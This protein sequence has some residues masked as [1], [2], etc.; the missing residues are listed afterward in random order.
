[1]SLQGA[2]RFIVAL[3][4]RPPKSLTERLQD[5]SRALREAAALAPQNDIVR[6]AF[7]KIQT[8]QAT[9]VLHKLCARFAREK[10]AQAGKD[11]LTY[12]KNS[13]G[14]PGDVAK[15]CLE[16]L[17]NAQDVQDKDVQ[18]GI[19]A[20]LLSESAA[21]KLAVAKQLGNFTTKTF[22]DFYEVGDQSANGMTIVV[23]DISSW[24]DQAE[25]H[26]CERDIFQLF[27]AKL[28]EAGHDLDG[29]ALH[30]I[31]RLLAADAGNLHSLLDEETF[32]TVLTC[33][34]YR[35]SIEVRSQATLATA[36]YLEAAEE[37]AQL[38]ISKF[39]EARI[40]RHL[41]EDLVLAFSAAAAIF[42]LAPSIASSLFLTEGFVP[43]LK[44]LLEQNKSEHVKQAGLEMLSAAC[45]DKA[46]REAISKY[47]AE[48]LLH[49]VETD[50]GQKLGLAAVILA[51]VRISNIRPT[52]SK[53]GKLKN[54]NQGAEDLLPL[55]KKM[56]VGDDEASKQSAIEGLA[57]ISVQPRA[58]EKLTKDKAF[59]ETLNSTLRL[60]HGNPNMIFGGLTIID[61]LTRYRA[62]LTEEQ[63]RVNE[64]KA[65]ANG[66]QAA[67]TMDPLDEDAIVTKRCTA[68][69]AAG[70][71]ST[72]ATISKIASSTS[73][74]TIFDILLSLSKTASLRGTIAKQGGVRLLLQSSA[75]IDR[76]SATHTRA[77]RSAAQALARI[78]I[79]IDPALVFTSGS[80]PLTSAIR[81][82]LFLLTDDPNHDQNGPRDLLPTFEALLALTNLASAPSPEAAETII[83]LAFPAIE[84]LL[85]NNNNLIQR[86]AT[87]LVCNLTACAS[88]IE[89]FADDSNPSSGR[90]LHI[91]LALADVDDMQTRRASAGA[92]ATITGF[93]GAVKQILARD[94]GVRILLNLCLDDDEGVVHRGVA[95]IKNLVWTDVKT[96]SFARQK[97]RDQGGVQTLTT[98][99]QLSKNKDILE[100]GASA[101]KALL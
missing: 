12:L 33:L 41:G 56:M 30:G 22:N 76:D 63:R 75:I 27:L 90:R 6:D 78:L 26:A 24:S 23:L 46:C 91:I 5:A 86:G 89:L 68:L 82:L 94:G 13:G 59:L 40:S 72:L 19:V 44:P 14:L 64:L 51:K 87:E 83:R 88:G 28:I 20:S 67:S 73:F 69:V 47:C 60:S 62:Q 34:D 9:H 61:N 74:S 10:D 80:P 1:M 55:F 21:V 100:L 53:A 36:K 42:P 38:A 49:V 50:D 81:P 4:R 29:R 77:L 3:K 71:V 39:V 7:T 17:R 48:W 66:A 45:L 58:K 98:A 18:D 79:S 92:L 93:E 32:S 52:T 16:I 99:L 84:D 85:L 25:R 95:C 101:L 35:L 96:Q 65:Y 8:D 70:V 57:Y 2:L 37:K 11:A 31:A 54:D 15:E 43:S 97:I